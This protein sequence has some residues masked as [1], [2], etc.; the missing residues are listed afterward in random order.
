MDGAT[1]AAAREMRSLVE[2]YKAKA[3]AAEQQ[4]AAERQQAGAQSDLWKQQ[5]HSLRTR[6]RADKERAA[7]LE[8]QL[9]AVGESPAAHRNTDRSDV[10]PAASPHSLGAPRSAPGAS[11]R[12][13]SELPATPTNGA[14][15]LR[16][17]VG[18]VVDRVDQAVDRSL[19][20]MV[21]RVDGLVGRLSRQASARQT[22]FTQ[23]PT[24][25]D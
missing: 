25:G 18:K 12:T 14:K 9:R 15:G 17:G 20:K 10:W 21:D 6:A 8:M 16:R 23:L 3:E 19:D 11:S 2:S 7:Q 24:D 13:A 4:L 1:Q 22:N 5:L